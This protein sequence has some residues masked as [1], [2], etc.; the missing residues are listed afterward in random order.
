MRGFI[1]FAALFASTYARPAA[2]TVR[3]RNVPSGPYLNE[4]SPDSSYK[5]MLHVSTP[6]RQE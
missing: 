6:A 2:G 3:P 1:A 4:T 5:V